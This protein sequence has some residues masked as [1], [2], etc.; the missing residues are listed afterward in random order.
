VKGKLVVAVLVALVLWGIYKLETVQRS[1]ED[2]QRR[3]YCFFEQRTLANPQLTAAQKH[4]TVVVFRRALALI[5]EPDC[6]H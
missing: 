6:H 5:G 2:A 1:A 3:V 4:E